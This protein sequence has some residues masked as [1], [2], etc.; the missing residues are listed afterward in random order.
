LFATLGA[1]TRK[2]ELGGGRSILLS[3][4]VGFVRRLP[5]FLVE[6]FHSTLSEVE[7][8]DF[9]LLVVDGADIEMDDKLRSVQK[10]LTELKVLEKPSILVLNQCDRL[11]KE[12]RTALHRSYP[13]GVFTSALTGEGLLDLHDAIKNLLA[14]QDEECEFELSAADPQTGRVLS[15]IARHGSI[16]EQEWQTRSDGAPP[17]L[18]V[19]ARLARRWREKLDRFETAPKPALAIS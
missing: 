8:A 16:I 18:W 5:H 14:Q 4:T 11:S 2:V 15:D 3:D 10:V 1:S 19:R 9:L 7:N 17:I 13:D 12:D 6:S